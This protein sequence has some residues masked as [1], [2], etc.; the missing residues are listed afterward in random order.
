MEKERVL[1][2]D[3]ATVKQ[4]LEER[5]K[6]HEEELKRLEEKHHTEV[7][8]S[9]SCHKKIHNTTLGKVYIYANKTLH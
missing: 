9:E 8:R 4:N 1:Q 7:R 3:L 5:Q 6:Q 2:E